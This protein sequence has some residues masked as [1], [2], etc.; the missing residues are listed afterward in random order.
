MPLLLVLLRCIALSRNVRHA[1]VSFGFVH[2]VGLVL[3]N[4]RTFSCSIFLRQKMRIALRIYAIHRPL[5]L[6]LELIFKHHLTLYHTL[7]WTP[8][9]HYLLIFLNSRL[10][11]AAVIYLFRLVLAHF[12]LKGPMWHFVMVWVVDDWRTSSGVF[13]NLDSSVVIGTLLMF[14]SKQIHF[15]ISN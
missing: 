7:W 10:M 3:L 11:S 6:L 1:A 2:L 15:L 8:I 14:V 13:F 12:W 9:L 4:L 5:L